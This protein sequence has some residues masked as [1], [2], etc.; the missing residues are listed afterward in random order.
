MLLLPLF[1]IV[2]DVLSSI[3]NEKFVDRSIQGFMVGRDEVHI[4]HLQFSDDT[5]LFSAHEDS[6]NNL[7]ESIGWFGNLSGLKVNLGKSII[8]GI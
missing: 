7:W 1:V 2:A 5:L 4:N 3:L 6:M 8:A